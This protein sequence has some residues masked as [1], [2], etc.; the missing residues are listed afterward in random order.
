MLCSMSS[1]RIGHDLATE[2]Q[3]FLRLIVGGL[4]QLFW[5]RGGEFQEL[6]HHP[7]FDP[8]V[9]P[10]NCHDAGGRAISLLMFY[11]EIY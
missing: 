6:G 7:H 11:D 2:Q 4:V 8:Y 3:Q 10:W 1:Q 9:W 5:G